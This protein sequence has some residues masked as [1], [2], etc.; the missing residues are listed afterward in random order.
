MS[1]KFLVF[2]THSPHFRG[3]KFLNEEHA[4]NF[5]ELNAMTLLANMARQS[6]WE[7]LSGDVFVKMNPRFERAVC[8]SREAQ[9]KEFKTLLKLGVEPR[10]LFTGESPN[11]SWNF[12]HNVGRLSHI[13]KHVCLFRGVK[14]RIPGQVKFHNHYWPMIRPANVSFRNFEE[15][16][17]LV[18]VASFKERF[19]QNRRNILSRI[20][21]PWRWL[22]IL[23]Y[24]TI[25]VHARFPDL[26]HERL[27]AIKAFSGF[28]EFHLYGRYWDVARQYVSEI[29]KLSFANSPDP[30]PDKITAMGN[31]KFT[32]VLENCVFPGYL[33]EKIFDAMLAGTV[34]VYYG[35]PDIQDFIPMDCF[36]DFR[37]YNG[38]KNLWA[39]L[40]SWS[41]TQ[42]QVKI[43]AIRTFL[44]SNLFDPFRAETVAEDYFKWLTQE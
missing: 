28:S 32:L 40:S 13:F 12:Y 22:R 36:I 2:E 24:Q 9:S 35:A 3:N 1:G 14:E 42:W 25:D 10:L 17:L 27:K 37:N 29:K 38:F 26:Y 16:K 44:N 5:P 15:R 8:I 19:T 30:V 20:Y 33:T 18:M 11:V 23:Y 31:F 21:S 4:R 6:D 41:S 43:D 7:V 34:P 39:D